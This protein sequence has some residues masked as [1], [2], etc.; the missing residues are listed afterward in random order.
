LIIKTHIK[1]LGYSGTL[2]LSELKRLSQVNSWG[3]L[4]SQ[5]TYVENSRPVRDSVSKE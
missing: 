2:V 1:T 5:F 4:A 3:S